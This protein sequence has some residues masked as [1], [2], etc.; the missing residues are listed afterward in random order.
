M[1]C[2]G[3]T[4]L[5]SHRHSRVGGETKTGSR[6]VELR[7]R[8]Y[9]RSSLRHRSKAL[10]ARLWNPGQRD[11]RWHRRWNIR[12]LPLWKMRRYGYRQGSAAPCPRGE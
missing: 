5:P 3:R 1:H 2:D 10:N 4:Q 7:V 8:E 9:S 11:R 6:T 12:K